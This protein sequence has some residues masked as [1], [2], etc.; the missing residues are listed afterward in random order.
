MGK[1]YQY[2]V[3]GECEQKLIEELKIYEM[4]IPGKVSVFNAVQNHFKNAQLMQLKRETTVILV[5]DTDKN[6]YDVLIENIEYLKNYPTIKEVWIVPQIRN[7]EDE[8]IYSTDIKT[9]KQFIPS[10]SKS[11]FKRDFRAEKRIMEKLN[12]HNFRMEKLWCRDYSS[13]KRA[14]INDGRKLK[15]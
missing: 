14:F 12:K 15:L 2:Y 9:I 1:F 6:D 7:L 3:E 13:E 10:K 8:L 5:F 4:V 11:D